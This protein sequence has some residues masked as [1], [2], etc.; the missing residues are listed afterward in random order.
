MSSYVFNLKAFLFAGLLIGSVCV[1]LLSAMA[2]GDK[3][4]DDNSN[5][6]VQQGFAI[7][8]APLNLHGKNRALVGLGSYLVNALGGCNDCHTCPTYTPGVEHNPFIGGDGQLNAQNHLAGGVHFGPFVSANLT[9]DANGKPAGLTLDEF[10]TT[11]RTGHDPD[12]PS[13]FLQVMP[14]PLLRHATDRDLAAIYE[15]LSTIPS[16]TPGTCSGPGEATFPGP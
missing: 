8:P 7:A 2:G 3:E 10:R 12:D 5:S 14:W 13:E 11:L 4:N 6:R 15:Y 16:A 9:P 1:S